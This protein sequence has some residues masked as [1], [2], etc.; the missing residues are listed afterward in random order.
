VPSARH[1]PA[2]IDPGGQVFTPVIVQQNWVYPP[3]RHLVPR[4]QFEGV[5]TTA[6]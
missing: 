2:I 5:F 4:A 1:H 3:S 6:E